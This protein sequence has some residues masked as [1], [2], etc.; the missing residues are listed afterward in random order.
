MFFEDD[1]PLSDEAD[2]LDSEVPHRQQA[3]GSTSSIGG[4]STEEAHSKPSLF[5]DDGDWWLPSQATNGDS[6]SADAHNHEDGSEGFEDHDG[7]RGHRDEGAHE[8]DGSQ[9]GQ[10]EVNTTGRGKYNREGKA[11]KLS[12]VLQREIALHLDTIKEVMLCSCTCGRNCTGRFSPNLVEE[13]R[14]LR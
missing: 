14:S 12:W 2:G 3:D 4:R 6:D 8:T 7:H 9:S 1:V 10:E 13:C 11:K 5:Q